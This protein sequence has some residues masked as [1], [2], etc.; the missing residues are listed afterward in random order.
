MLKQDPVD[1]GLD[2]RGGMGC[3]CQAV[4]TTRI[5]EIMFGMAFRRDV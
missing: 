3:S 1:C 4:Y 5:E 2:N